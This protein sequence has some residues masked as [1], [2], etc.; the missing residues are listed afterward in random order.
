MPYFSFHFYFNSWW[1]IAT[2]EILHN[3]FL[4]QPHNRLTTA[5]TNP[6][7][8]QSV[9]LKYKIFK[10]QAMRRSHFGV[11]VYTNLSKEKSNIPLFVES[12]LVFLYKKFLLKVT[13]CCNNS[14]IVFLLMVAAGNKLSVWNFSKH[15][16]SLHRLYLFSIYLRITLQCLNLWKLFNVLVI[17]FVKYF[18][19]F[20]N[21]EMQ[22]AWSSKKQIE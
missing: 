5:A 1:Y 10:T 16:S 14:R 13:N 12:F 2:V 6:S 19:H 20:C 4:S 21:F 18:T 15:F 11:H 8:H 3:I 17:C 7:H 9:S 22:I